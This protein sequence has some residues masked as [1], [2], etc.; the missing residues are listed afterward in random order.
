VAHGAAAE[1]SPGRRRTGAHHGRSPLARRGHRRP[2]RGPTPV[3]VRARGKHLLHRLDSRGSPSTRTCGWRANGGS[4]RPPRCRDGRA[5]A[6]SRPAC[7]TGHRAVDRAG[8]ATGDA[9][10][11]GRPTPRSTLVGHLGPDVLGPDWDP[12]RSVAN[13][14]AYEGFVGDA[15]LDQRTLAVSGR[16]GRARPS[17]PNASCVAKDVR[18]WWRAARPPRRPH[19]H[20][21]GSRQGRTAAQSSTGILRRGQES[22]VHGRSGRPCRRCGDTIRVAMTR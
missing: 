10:R 17:S 5:S 1:P 16:S 19:P 11:R 21:D 3:E 15:L 8:P 12:A 13:L 6:R 7:G 9:R 2:D 18:R 20:A 22:W 14:A 4:P